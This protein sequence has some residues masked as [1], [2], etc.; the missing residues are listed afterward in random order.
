MGRLG[1]LIKAEAGCGA[2]G[3]VCSHSH[4]GGGAGGSYY[5]VV[6]HKVQLVCLP[7]FFDI[8]LDLVPVV[9]LFLNIFVY[10]CC[11]LRFVGDLVV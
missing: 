3:T 11:D 5:K 9:D 10:L 1:D 2:H 8:D 7:G 4:L 6:T